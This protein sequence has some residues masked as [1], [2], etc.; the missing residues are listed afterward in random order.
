MTNQPS[1]QSLAQAVQHYLDLM[2]HPDISRFDQVFHP[3]AQLHGFQEGQ[4][5]MWT[6]QKYRDVAAGRPSPKTMKAPRQEEVLLVDFASATQ[7]MVKVRVRINAVVFVDHLTYHCIDGAWLVTSKAYHV[8][9]R[10]PVA[11]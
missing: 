6:A 4:M 5:T 10:V 7:A 8:E 11:A 3:T 1:L 9:G 2:Y